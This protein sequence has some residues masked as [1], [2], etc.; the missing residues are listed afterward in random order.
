MRPIAESWLQKKSSGGCSVLE[1][2]GILEDSC[3]GPV[4][5]GDFT[6]HIKHIIKLLGMS[7]VKRKLCT[8]NILY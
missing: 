3:S 7:F 2:S 1:D 6:G 5:C 4:Y 8:R